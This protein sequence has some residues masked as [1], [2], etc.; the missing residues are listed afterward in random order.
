MGVERSRN[1]RVFFSEKMND[2]SGGQR[3]RGMVRHLEVTFE[4]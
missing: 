4:R 1:I 3:G 2:F